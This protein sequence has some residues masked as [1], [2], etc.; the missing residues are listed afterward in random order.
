MADGARY[1]ILASKVQNIVL[2]IK[3]VNSNVEKQAAE[4]EEE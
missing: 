2:A 1:S 4:A 3:N